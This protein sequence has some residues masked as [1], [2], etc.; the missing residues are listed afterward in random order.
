M[1]HSIQASFEAAVNPLH[2][3]SI[4]RTGGKATTLC[5]R[6][7]TVSDTCLMAGSIAAYSGGE[8]ENL[9]VSKDAIL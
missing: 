5:L 6:A 3:A 2:C 1:N 7:L 4:K 9:K 8:S